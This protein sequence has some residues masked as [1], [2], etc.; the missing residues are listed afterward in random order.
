[1]PEHLK[2]SETMS[3]ESFL[4]IGEDVIIG[5]VSIDLDK[6]QGC[7]YCVRACAADSI[8]LKDKK[9]RMIEV[10]PMCMACGDCMAICPEQAIAIKT[11]IRFF[12]A[13]RYL[14]RGEPAPPRRF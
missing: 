7:G 13:F 11:Y 3:V 9:A 8:E 1:M 14:D 2:W 10:L 4:K 12:K 5:E 6:C